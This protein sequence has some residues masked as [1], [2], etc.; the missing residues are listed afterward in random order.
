MNSF[1]IAAAAL[2]LA[3]LVLLLRPWWRGIGKKNGEGDQHRR[4][5]K[6]LATRRVT[7]A[8]NSD[9]ATS[10]LNTT[11]HRDRLAELERDYANHLISAADYAE[12]RDE[13]QHQLLDDTSAASSVDASPKRRWDGWVLA[14]L[15]PAAAIGLYVLLGNPDALLSSAERNAQAVATMNDMISQ[16]EKKL[17]QTPDDMEGWV[18]LARA[19]KVMSRWD[20]AERAYD[21]AK[22]LLEK[23]ASL[24]AELADVLLQKTDNFA[25]RPHELIAQALQLEP[26]NGKALL[27]AGAEALAGKSYAAAVGHWER[28]QAQMDPASDEAQMIASGIARAREL[29]GIKVGA[30]DTPRSQP[31]AGTASTPKASDAATLAS[32]VSG[33]VELS[34]AL[35]AQ[36]TPEETVF[37][38][39]RAVNGP[40]MPLAVQRVRVADLPYDFKLDDSQAM[41]PQNRIS[42][43]QELRIEVRVSKSG[44]AMPGKGDLTGQSGIVK[45]GSE[46][47]RVLVDQVTE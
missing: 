1:F 19:Y 33:R 2:T 18:M 27:L 31:L 40:R 21:H 17:A 11:I 9:D 32:A 12:A 34:P 4:P 10:A 29:G 46:N 24:L 36:T 42:S 45:P 37:I 30:G 5:E 26:D 7:S 43:A 14:T 3:A 25:G 44:Q 38:F 13:L 16:L 47:I 39:A 15:L 35:R 6:G 22:P 41:S 20:D 23:N 28:L 8:D